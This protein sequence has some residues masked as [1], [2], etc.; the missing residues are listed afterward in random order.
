MINVEYLADQEGAN[1]IGSC[2]SCGMFCEK[3]PK[4]IRLHLGHRAS[5][6]YQGIQF[7]LCNNCKQWLQNE[8]KES[9]N[10]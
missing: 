7:C 8:L 9:E 5:G 10:G 1:R 4:M 6:F 3:S 2:A